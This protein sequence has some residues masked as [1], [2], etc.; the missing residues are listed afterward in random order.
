MSNFK[1]HD[2][3]SAPAESKPLLEGSIKAFGMLPNLHAVM[4]ESPM[5]LKSYQQLHE[6]FLN[7]SF[8]ADEKTVVWQTINVE[9]NCHY[10]VPAHSAIAKSMGVDDALNEALRNQSA[11][12]NEKLQALH[13]TTLAV[14]RG[15]GV[16]SDEVLEAFYAQGYNQQHLLDIV[17]GLAQKVMSNYVNHFADTPVDEP[18]KAFVK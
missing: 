7:S 14:V 3:E 10:C 9:H 5:N 16:V 8:D 6:N 12:P 17:V 11:M 15:R 18:F 1:L 2:L 13:D 4:A